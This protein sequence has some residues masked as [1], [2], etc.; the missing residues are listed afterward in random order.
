[1]R[2]GG[3]LLLLFVLCM[4]VKYA[5]W[6][7]L[8]AAI[9]AGLA[10][11]WKLTEWLD[12]GLDRRESRRKAKRLERAAIAFRADEQNAWVL[13]GDVRGFYGDYPPAALPPLRDHGSYLRL[14]TGPDT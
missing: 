7:G 13:S 2:G 6:I 12:R 5:V 10:L 8:A 9:I 1:M 14:I 4:I 11:L 3:L